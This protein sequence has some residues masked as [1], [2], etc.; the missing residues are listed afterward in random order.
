MGDQA[1]SLLTSSHTRVNYVHVFP[2][3]QILIIRIILY[4]SLI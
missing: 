2:F 3:N 1:V 4:N